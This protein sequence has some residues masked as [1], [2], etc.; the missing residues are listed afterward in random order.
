MG[1]ADFLRAQGTLINEAKQQHAQKVIADQLARDCTFA[2][3]TNAYRNRPKVDGR[4]PIGRIS[5]GSINL[6]AVARKQ[7]EEKEK[8]VQKGN[9]QDIAKFD[10]LYK[11]RKRQMD[12][13]DK[14]K[15]DYEFERHG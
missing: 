14:S 12:K 8:A 1:A 15:E 13:T 4:P 10:Q 5:T 2:P 7:E 11:L 9:D 6:G 3:Q